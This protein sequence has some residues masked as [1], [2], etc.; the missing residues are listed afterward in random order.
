MPEELRAD[1]GRLLDQ[2]RN[3][4]LLA[5]SRRVYAERGLHV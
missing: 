1:A 4:G 2:V 5:R 3:A